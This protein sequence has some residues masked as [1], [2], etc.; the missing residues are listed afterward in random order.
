MSCLFSKTL[1]ANGELCDLCKMV[2][3]FLDQELGANATR[4][5]VERALDTLCDKLPAEFKQSVSGVRFST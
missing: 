5:D 4:R 2:I 3:T 1:S